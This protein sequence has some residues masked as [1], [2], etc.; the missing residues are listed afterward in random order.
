[1]VKLDVEFQ[2]SAKE[3]NVETARELRS[4]GIE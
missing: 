3:W 1:M 2:N 4:A